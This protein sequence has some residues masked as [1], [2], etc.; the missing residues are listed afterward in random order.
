[1][2]DFLRGDGWYAQRRPDGYML[3]WEHAIPEGTRVHIATITEAE[4]ERLADD[5]AALTSIAQA[6]EHEAVG[7]TMG[8]PQVAPERP[9]NDA[10]NIYG[11][12]WIARRTSDGYTLSWLINDPKVHF[13]SA[14]RSTP[15]TEAKFDRLRQ[16]PDAFD[17]ILREHNLNE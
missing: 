17:E 15:I 8:P 13:M 11:P 3:T 9:P 1:M 14:E 2:N 10:D 12:G 7:Y 6:H 16:N 4:F 5:P